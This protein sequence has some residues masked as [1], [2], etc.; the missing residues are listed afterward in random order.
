MNQT[1]ST[2]QAQSVNLDMLVKA[3]NSMSPE[4]IGQWMR[5]KG[6]PPEMYRLVLP[7]SMAGDLLFLPSY[8]SI[9]TMVDVPIFMLRG[10]TEL[11]AIDFTDVPAAPAPMR[12]GRNP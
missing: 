3:A 4:P 11:V 5:S 7:R 9:S 10:I 8:V 1:A 6:Y 2:G 12:Y